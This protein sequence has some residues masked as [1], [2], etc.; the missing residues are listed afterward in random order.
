LPDFFINPPFVKGDFKRGEIYRVFVQ[1]LTVE[2]IMTD[3]KDDNQK[4][5]IPYEPPQLFDLGGGVAYAAVACNPGGS[6]TGRC[7][8]GSAATIGKCQIGNIAGGG[9]CKGGGIP[10]GRCKGGG[11]KL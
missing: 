11:S 4:T 10:S 9:D 2:G 6:P 8:D 1:K 5:R 7:T 3:S